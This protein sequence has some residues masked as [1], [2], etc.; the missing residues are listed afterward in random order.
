MY[1]S[2]LQLTGDFEA[3]GAWQRIPVSPKGTGAAFDEAKLQELLFR[4]VQTLPLQEIDPAYA[5]AVPVCTELGT[6]GGY[7]DALYL[8]P[9]GRI[10]LAEFK[11]W[12]NPSARR[13]VI[14][15]ILDYA[16]VLASWSYDDLEREVRKR[17]QKS[18]FEIVS[19][20][21]DNLQEQLFVDSIVRRLRR[22]EFLLLIIG[23]GIREDVEEIVAHVQEH[24]GLRFNLALIEAAIYR[25]TD[26]GDLLVQPRVL[27][28]TE[29]IDR[30]VLTS[31]GNG[32]VPVVPGNGL[33]DYE[34]ECKRFWTAVLRDFAFDDP[35]PEEPSPDTN[36]TVW[37]KV[38]GSGWGDWGMSFAAFIDRQQSQI[39]TYLMWRKGYPENGRIFD[40]IVGT[41]ENGGDLSDSLHGWKLWH[42]PAGVPRLGF[43]RATDFV[44]NCKIHDFDESVE[45]MRVHFNRLVTALHTE[46]LSRL[47]K[48]R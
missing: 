46:C 21:K 17:T 36:A 29:I 38:V 16:R 40:A 15:Q 30:T 13:A 9:A 25:H 44:D 5:D 31:L 19:A 4:H 28:R 8:T 27:A 33:T 43:V 1:G 11:L 35:K 24:S 26:N 47:G 2:L 42:S 32:E 6:R 23:D 39:G 18:P 3:K 12:K 14:G 37:V 45:W 10:V 34:K 7:V 20:G 48:S 41:L 22:G